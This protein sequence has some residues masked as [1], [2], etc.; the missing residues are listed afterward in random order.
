MAPS[1]DEGV[2]WQSQVPLILRREQLQAEFRQPAG[3]AEDE[4]EGKVNT[5]AKAKAKAKGRA[6]AKGEAKA[7]A[8]AKGKATNAK[9]NATATLEADAETMA[10][11]EN[12]EATGAGSKASAKAKAKA[13][14]GKS[15]KEACE[16]GRGSEVKISEKTFAGRYVGSPKLKAMRDVFQAEILPKVSRHS[17][18]QDWVC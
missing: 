2:A 6:K 15:K 1:M 11:V 14:A 17:A 16:D 7:K 18:L 9:G 12:A 8:K 3:E 5:R 10:R 13:D 4:P